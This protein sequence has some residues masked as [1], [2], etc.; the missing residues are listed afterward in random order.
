MFL[1]FWNQLLLEVG[2]GVAEVEMASVGDGESV[3]GV[4]VSWALVETKYSP[5]VGGYLLFRGVAI[6]S[7]M[8]LDDR[9]FIFGDREVAGDGGSDGDTLS[10][11]EFEH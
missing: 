1:L 9:G 5:E 4:E 6:T 8:L 11:A 2:E 7:N 3:G 10:T